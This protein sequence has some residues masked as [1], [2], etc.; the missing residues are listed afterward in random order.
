MTLPETIVNLSGLEQL[1]AIFAGKTGY[2]GIAKTLDL[3]PVST[4]EERNLRW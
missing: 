3:G 1:R 4:E 2:E